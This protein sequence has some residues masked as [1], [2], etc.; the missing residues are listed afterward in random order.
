M[1]ADN[2]LNAA[3]QNA[4]KSTEGQSYSNVPKAFNVI[5]PNVNKE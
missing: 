1:C 4:D 5:L 2:K 3:L